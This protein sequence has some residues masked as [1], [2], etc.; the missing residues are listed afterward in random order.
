MKK[1]SPFFLALIISLLLAQVSCEED[2]DN[3][4]ET[5][6]SLNFENESHNAGSNCMECH[7]PGAKG[8]GWFSVAGTVYDKT[9]TSAFPNTE[10]VFY[11]GPA[12]TGEIIKTIEV[13]ALGNFYTTE[14]INFD[15]DIYVGVKGSSSVKY[16]ISAIDNGKCNACHGLNTEKIW[17]N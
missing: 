3:G 1:Y 5:L 15:N 4:D 11:R 14:D 12:G 7:K 10:V 6:I 17:V 8:E 9:K 16:M 13:D 2:N